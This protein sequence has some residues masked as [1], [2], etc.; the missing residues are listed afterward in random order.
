MKKG[1]RRKNQ[2]PKKDPNP[3]SVV[4]SLGEERK[5]H[6]SA[7]PRQLGITDFVFAPELELFVARL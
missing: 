1:R 5:I 2:D 6:E 3:S 4:P 7:K